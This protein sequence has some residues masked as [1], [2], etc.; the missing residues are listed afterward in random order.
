MPVDIL[1]NTG[2][3][4]V[5]LGQLRAVLGGTGSV[6]GGINWYWLVLGATG[7]EQGDTGCQCDMLLENIWFI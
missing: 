3:Y 7:S 2:L 6:L 1:S 4:G 5:V